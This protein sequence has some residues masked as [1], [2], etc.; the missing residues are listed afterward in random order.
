[1]SSYLMA[2][3]RILEKI[4]VLSNDVY[5][6]CNLILKHTTKSIYDVTGSTDLD[7]VMERTL[8]QLCW[9]WLD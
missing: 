1:M 9:Y 5:F 6:A 2:L 3:Y 4:I 8:E 7:I